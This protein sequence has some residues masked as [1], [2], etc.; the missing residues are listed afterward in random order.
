MRE[1]LLT[2][3]ERDTPQ[4]CFCGAAMKR[5]ASI[6][7]PPVMKQTGNDMALAS[8]NS[9]DTKHMKPEQI[10]SA[11]RGLERPEKTIY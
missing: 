8:L 11:V 10:A 7:Q 9:R 3:E 6:P 1:A 5:V 4:T 2:I